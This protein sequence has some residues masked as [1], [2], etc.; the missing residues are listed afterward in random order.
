MIRIY[1]SLCGSDK[2][3]KIEKE[4]AQFDFGVTHTLGQSVLQ[5]SYFDPLRTYSSVGHHQFHAASFAW[6]RDIIVG[7]Q[8]P[9]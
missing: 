5:D 4:K 7:F 9:N 6:P 2:Y 8:C 1:S 3:G